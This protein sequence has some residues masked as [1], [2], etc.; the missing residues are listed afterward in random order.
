SSE[1]REGILKHGCTWEHP[2]PLPEA[3]PQPS[4]EA[5]VAD[6][7]D[8]IA[9]TNHDLDDGLRSGLLRGEELLGL[10]LWRETRAEVAERVGSAREAGL[11]AQVIVGLIHRL[12]TDLLRATAARLAAAGVA[13]V[14][15]VRRT[16]ERFVGFSPETEKLVRELRGH[17][18]REFYQHPRVLQVSGR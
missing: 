1:T 8:E 6:A 7:A 12:V 3:T 2:L 16:P 5:Q 18:G 13:S 9:Y 17:L 4:L 14:D 10:A 11:V 15:A